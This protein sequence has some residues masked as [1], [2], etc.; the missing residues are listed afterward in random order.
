MD[1]NIVSVLV[2]VVIAVGSFLAKEAITQA[3][4]GIRFRRRL[5]ADL[6]ATVDGHKKHDLAAINDRIHNMSAS[7]IWDSSF[8]GLADISENSHH[9]RSHEAS[10][11]F[12][13]YDALSRIAEIRSEFNVAIRNM[14]VDESVRN[15][16]KALAHACLADLKTNYGEILRRGTECLIELGL[17]HHLLDIDIARYRSELKEM[18]ESDKSESAP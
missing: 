16:H 4:A 9:L 18:L 6:K 17:N 1:L 7:F 14:V 5:V 15:A 13:F 10:L 12:H 8:G 11:C 2:G 3:I